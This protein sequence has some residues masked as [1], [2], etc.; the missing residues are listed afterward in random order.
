[1]NG[2]RRK[3]ISLLMFL[4]NILIA[5]SLMKKKIKFSLLVHKESLSGRKGYQSIVAFE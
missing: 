5:I 1:M 4:R 3:T 2:L